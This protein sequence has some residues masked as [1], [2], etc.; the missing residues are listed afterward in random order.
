L[1]KPPRS[2]CHSPDGLHRDRTALPI[3]QGNE[4][5]V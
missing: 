5:K 1:A 2:L 4:N 3:T